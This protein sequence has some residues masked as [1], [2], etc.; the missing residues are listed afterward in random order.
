MG[1]LQARPAPINS[2]FSCRASTI[3]VRFAPTSPEFVGSIECTHPSRQNTEIKEMELAI[4]SITKKYANFSGR[5]RRKE[6]WLFMLSYFI[7]YIIFIFIDILLDLFAT[8]SEYG[9]FSTIF[10][11]LFIIPSLAVS[12]RRL[13]DTDRTGWW[14]L[15]QIIPLIG[16]VWIIVLWCLRGTEGENRFGSDP[17]G[18]DLE[19]VFGD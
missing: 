18:P 2:T 16:F 1:G 19:S 11:L 15:I 7:I 10:A 9:L 3:L 14:I 13:H 12:I 8:D 4:G 17:L 5:A 6:F